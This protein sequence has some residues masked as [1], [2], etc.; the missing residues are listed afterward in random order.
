MVA[1][2]PP[3]T[4]VNAALCSVLLVG[5][6][7]ST[8][9]SLRDADPSVA[10]E[11]S[12]ATAVGVTLSCQPS[13]RFQLGGVEYEVQTFDDLVAEQDVGEVF[14]EDLVL[15]SAI[16]NCV[17]FVV[18]RDGE[19]SLPAGTTVYEIVGVDPAEALTASYGNGHYLRFLA[20]P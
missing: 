15:P 18:L 8:N 11:A 2:F 12:P 17:P 3:R 19:G 1:I 20:N 7:A 4:L 14:A 5:C 10:P 9:G 6:A 13:P 16:T